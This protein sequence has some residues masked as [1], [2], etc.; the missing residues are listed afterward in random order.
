[1][2]ACPDKT[3]LLHGLLDDELDAVNAAACEAHL[4]T[5]EACDAEFRRL[6]ALRDMMGAPGVAY[7]APDRLR[8]GIEA[9]LAAETAQAPKARRRLAA[10]TA[11]GVGGVGG[12]LAAGLAVMLVLPQMTEA[13]VER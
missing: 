4:K 13:G 8:A 1:M 2:S 12:L 7:R 9:V 3:A 10:W 6:Q 11:G 5:C